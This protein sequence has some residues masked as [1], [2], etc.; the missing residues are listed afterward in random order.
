MEILRFSIQWKKFVC[1]QRVRLSQV[2]D[3]YYN[4][5]KSVAFDV[6]FYAQEEDQ[7]TQQPIVISKPTHSNCIQT[8]T[9]THLCHGRQQIPHQIHHYP[10][11]TNSVRRHDDDDDDDDDF[12]FRPRRT[13]IDHPTSTT[14]DLST[15]H[16]QNHIG[17]Y[18]G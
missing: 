7:Q 2:E 14:H 12:V 17:Q 11:S 4:Q 8:I 1:E 9:F 13:S 5:K 6:P 10:I 16:V 3:D 18:V 15:S